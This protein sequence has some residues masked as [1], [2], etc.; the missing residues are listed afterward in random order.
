MIF[1]CDGDEDEKGEGEQKVEKGRR[2][3]EEGGGKERCPGGTA[4]VY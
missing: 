3:R 2:R 1:S 4:G